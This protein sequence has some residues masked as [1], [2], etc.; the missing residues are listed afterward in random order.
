MFWTKKWKKHVK[1]C[2]SIIRITYKNVYFYKIFKVLSQIKRENHVKKS[3]FIK[4]YKVLKDEKWKTPKKSQETQNKNKKHWAVIFLN[5]VFS[6][7][8]LVWRKKD[9]QD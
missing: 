3:I 8:A 6:H 4:I 7:P 9:A 2:I 1:K 5:R